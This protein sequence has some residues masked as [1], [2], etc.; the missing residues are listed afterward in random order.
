MINRFT[1]VHF[2]T[3][4]VMTILLV[5]IHADILPSIVAISLLAMSN[6]AG[7]LEHGHKTR[8]LVNATDIARD[9]PPKIVKALQE[10]E[11]AVKEH[12]ETKKH[13]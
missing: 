11:K 9:A 6:I 13:K 10:L 8:G 5:T 12:N 3:L 1:F 7:F 2:L 4:A